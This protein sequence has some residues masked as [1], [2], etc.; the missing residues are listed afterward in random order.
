[1]YLADITILIYQYKYQYAFLEAHFW[2]LIVFRKSIIKR[3]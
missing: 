1:M 3:K 2:C